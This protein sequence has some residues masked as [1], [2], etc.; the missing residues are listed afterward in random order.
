VSAP[1]IVALHGCMQ[2]AADFAVATRFDRV[3]QH[4]GAY[5]L[6]PEQSTIANSRQCWNWFSLENQ[7]RLQGEPAAL[8]ALLEKICMRYPIDY[9]R[10]FVCGFSAGAVM[11]A[12]LAE[13]APDVIAAVGLMAGVPLHAAYDLMSAQALMAG[14]RTIAPPAVP[15]APGAYRR[16]RAMVWQGAQDDVVAPINATMLACQFAELCA[17]PPAAPEV[18]TRGDAEIRRWRETPGGAVRIEEWRV[19]RMRHAWSGGSPRGSFT[20]PAGPHAS[21]AMAAFFLRDGSV[22]RPETA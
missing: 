22:T 12:I 14:A 16:L 13:Q 1:L 5:V 18:E 7:S 10:I 2:S 17:L 6:Y 8:L 3:G 9:A 19:A 21:E 11:A 4:A 15:V 20:W